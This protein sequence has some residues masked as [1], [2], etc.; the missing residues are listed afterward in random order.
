MAVWYD[1]AVR[2]VRLVEVR[3]GEETLVEVAL[4]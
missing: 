2:A 4:P 3:A 1:G